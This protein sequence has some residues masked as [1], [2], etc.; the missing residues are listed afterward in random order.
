MQV[1]FPS[2][3]SGA[4]PVQPRYQNMENMDIVDKTT[5]RYGTVWTLY[6]HM[7]GVDTSY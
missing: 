2:S 6:H 4:V 1:A 5:P 3:C 7:Y